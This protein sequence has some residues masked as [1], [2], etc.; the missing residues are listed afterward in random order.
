VKPEAKGWFSWLRRGAQKSAG[1]T[2]TAG[3]H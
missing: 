1:G 2:G 3:G